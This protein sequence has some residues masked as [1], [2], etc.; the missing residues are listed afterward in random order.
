MNLG[1]LG[2]FKY[3]KFFADDLIAALGSI[4][5]I[6]FPPIIK[7]MLSVGISFYTFQTLSYTIDVYRGK[8][9]P[10]R[11]MLDFFVFVAFF[12]QWVAGLIERAR[13]LLPQFLNPRR[14][15]ADPL[16]LFQEDGPGGQPRPDHGQCLRDQSHCRGHSR[17]QRPRVDLRNG[18]F[19]LPD[20]LRL[21]GL[22]GHRHPHGSTVRDPPDAEFFLPLLLAKRCRI[23]AAAAHSSFDLV[24]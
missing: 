10:T 7:I 2:F 20:L 8:F 15:P 13:T 12:P 3:F 1:L 5:W 6:V 19:R 9:E 22:F 11:K 24:P 18:L 4:G 16:R 14:L 21:L 23:L 17:G